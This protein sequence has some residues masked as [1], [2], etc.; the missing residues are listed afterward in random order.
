MDELN[1]A[2]GDFERM[3]LELLRSEA[4]RMIGSSDFPALCQSLIRMGQRSG[5]RDRELFYRRAYVFFADRGRGYNHALRLMRN[6]FSILGVLPASGFLLPEG[7]DEPVEV[8]SP[9]IVS[10]SCP[11]VSQTGFPGDGEGLKGEKTR[12][13]LS[14]DLTDAAEELDKPRLQQFFLNVREAVKDGQPVVVFRLPYMPREKAMGKFRAISRFFTAEPVFFR[15]F[16]DEDILDMAELFFG[17][18]GWSVQESAR[19]A[20]AEL[21]EHAR[22]DGAF[23]GSHTVR[24]LVDDV[25]AAALSA[26][27][28]NGERVIG[29]EEVRAAIRFPE[30]Y[31]VGVGNRQDFREIMAELDDMV[32]MAEVKR[33]LEEIIGG[34]L[35]ARKTGSEL[36]AMHM[37]IT[38]NPGTGKTMVA[39]VIAR[40]MK[41]SGLLPVGKLVEC[42][43]ADLVAQYVGQSAPLTRDVCRSAY[44]SVLFIDEAYIL[45]NSTFGKE[46][47]AELIVQMENH[48]EEF[49]VILAGYAGE[50]RE[51]LEVN[52]GMTRRIPYQIHLPNCDGVQLA[53]IFFRLLRKQREQLG[54]SGVTL[55]C[56]P[57]LQVH[58]EDFFHSI[59]RETLEDRTFGNGGYAR[60]LLEKTV[61]AARVR[62]NGDRPLDDLLT[63]TE[64]RLETADFDYAAS[65]VSP[66]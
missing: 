51:M 41:A 55:S 57:E 1:D 10:L 39:R 29:P 8:P 23:Y 54:K 37:V 62:M 43:S 11:T 35:F 27:A 36:P 24:K 61:V 38:G 31:Q 30:L 25:I 58:A 16:T 12:C 26:E 66:C 5:E 7:S 60:S 63:L 34:M 19:S 13:I 18:L 20:F 3:E 2:L 9:P 15:P 40:A 48:R 6:L 49:M 46:S 47:I 53:A 4:E 59:P 65:Q 56:A 45:S 44:G 33:S 21:V 14:V 64:I 52:P 22:E 32:G 50:M 28:E 17:E 42:S